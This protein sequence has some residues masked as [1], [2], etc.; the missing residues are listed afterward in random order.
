MID[1]WLANEEA[2]SQEEKTNLKAN[3][4]C[5]SSYGHLLFSLWFHLVMT[6]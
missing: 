4:E 5:H 6:V 2:A 1:M 3:G